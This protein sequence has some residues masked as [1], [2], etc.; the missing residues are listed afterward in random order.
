MRVLL[1]WHATPEEVRSVAQHLPE[2]VEVTALEYSP[3]LPFPYGADRRQLTRALAEADAVMTWVLPPESV[4]AATRLKFVSWLHSGCDRLPFALFRERGIQLANVPDAHQPAIAEH[5]WALLLACAKQVVRK[6]LAHVR[7]DY[8]PYWREPGVGTH[9]YG[10]T[11]VL[12]GL[13]GIGRRVAAV[14]KAFGMR[15]VAVKRD[16]TTGHEHADLVLGP[17]RLHEALGM[18]DFVLVAAPS[19]EATRGMIDAAALAAMRSHAYLVNIARGDLVDE[20]AVH[21]ALVE[22]RIAGFASD[23]WWDYTDAMPPDQHFGSP[24]RLGVHRLPQVVVSGDQASNVFFARD[25]MLRV[26][27]ENLAAFLRGE[28][29]RHLVDL[30]LGY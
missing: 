3:D 10:Q 18:G 9:L 24:S 13:G 1:G 7:G 27:T 17:D 6:H 2:G 14:A 28:R 19:T 23:V 11:L 20:V 22:E 30:S 29:P 26:G 16:P 25:A 4:E 5:A 8:V 15:V 12:I 21:R